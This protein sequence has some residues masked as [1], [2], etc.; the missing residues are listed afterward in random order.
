MAWTESMVAFFYICL[1]NVSNIVLCICL[2]VSHT[3]DGEHGTV[4]ELVAFL[5]ADQNSESVEFIS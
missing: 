5:I 3:W 4:V 1:G 2:H